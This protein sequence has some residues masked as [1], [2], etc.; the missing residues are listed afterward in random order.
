MNKLEFH[1]KNNNDVI[2]NDEVEYIKEDNDIIFSHNEVNYKVRYT[3]TSLFF[4]R[5]TKEDIFVID[6]SEGGYESYIE[7]KE[8]NLRFDIGFKKLCV[9][10]K[11][12]SVDI[13]YNLRGDEE[14]IRNIKI[15]II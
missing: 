7:L 13:T 12:D 11:E 2:Y 3:N 5:E 15:R 14:V 1:L 9:D 8:G 4:M 6:A 10:S